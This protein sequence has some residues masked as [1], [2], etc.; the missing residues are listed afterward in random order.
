M[1]PQ[2]N[3]NVGNNWQQAPYQN[4]MNSNQNPMNPNMMGGQDMNQSGII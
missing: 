2:S 3:G 1:Q 4:R